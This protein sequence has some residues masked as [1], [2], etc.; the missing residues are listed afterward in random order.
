M[1][2]ETMEIYLEYFT[3]PAA[4]VV[5]LVA[6]AYGFYRLANEH[7]LPLV[8]TGLREHFE[9]IEKLM[10]E[11]SKDRQVFREAIELLTNRL[12]NIES[13]VKEIKEKI[14]EKSK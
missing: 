13:D 12:D 2:D 1:E 10:E 6:L 9:H 5:I 4:A 7:L 14:D 11:H 3:G 8:R